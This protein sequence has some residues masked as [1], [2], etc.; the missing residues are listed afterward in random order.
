VWLV[1]LLSTGCATGGGGSELLGR[2]DGSLA[3]ADYRSAIALYDQFLQRSP[4]DPASPRA[5]ATRTVLERLIVSQGE[6]ER[7]RR[8]VSTRDADLGRLRAEGDRLRAEGDR[9][10]A[11][12]DR[13]RAEVE[14][15]RA[16]LQRLRTIDLRQLQ[17]PV[18]A[19][20]APP[21]RR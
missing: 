20:P 9:L 2:A 21:A 17:P 1:A 6:T 11:E 12:V 16:D 10:R 15:L 4:E 18:P 19:P 5:R 3:A 13:L 7:L 8:E 14:R